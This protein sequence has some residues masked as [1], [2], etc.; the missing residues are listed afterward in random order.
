MSNTTLIS[1][2]NLLFK[3]TDNGWELVL[4]NAET[5][6]DVIDNKLNTFGGLFVIS[7]GKVMKWSTFV[8]KKKIYLKVKDEAGNVSDISDCSVVSLDLKSIKEFSPSSRILDIDEYGNVVYSYDSPE[9]NTFYGG[10]LIDTEVGVYESEVFNGTNDLVSWRTITW[11]SVEPENTELNLQ[12]RYGDS[13]DDILDQEW[14]SNLVKDIDGFVAID[15]VRKQF[16]QF[17]AILKSRVKDISPSLTS[18]T[19][20]NL[21]SRATHFFTTNFVLSSRVK[22]GLL[23]DNH[24]IPVNAD[25]I[26]GIN[27]KNSVDFSDYQIIEPN[28]L[29]TTDAKQFGNNLRIGIKIISPSLPLPVSEDPYNS[30]THVCNIGF[31]FKNDTS[32]NKTYDF[33][34]RFYNDVNRTQLTYSFFSGNNQTG[35]TYGV[36]SNFPSTGLPISAGSTTAVS[37][38]PGNTLGSQVW[39][40]VI[41]AFDGSDFG[42]VNDNSSYVCSSC[43]DSEYDPYCS[44]QPK[45]MN[46][47]VVFTLDSGEQVQLNI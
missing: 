12:I 33:R 42:T 41:D 10:N 32:S 5:I 17:R 39:Y 25:I 9:D 7:D 1:N 44:E 35:W 8:P 34:V 3:K 13:T 22:S 2:K 20:K 31:N 19:I 21:T 14:S 30:I 47:A 16:I 24:V 37:F 27:T 36:N 18:V 23:T 29:F 4:K 46:L 6:N 28:R 11:T 40:L 15:Y 26:Y 43:T 45:V 38:V